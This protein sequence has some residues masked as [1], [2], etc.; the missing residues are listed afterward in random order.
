[1]ESQAQRAVD[2]LRLAINQC[3]TIPDYY[4]ERQKI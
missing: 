2:R 4:G 1:M 3:S